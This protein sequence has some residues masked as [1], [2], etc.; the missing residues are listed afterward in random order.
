MSGLYVA[1]SQPQL[2][3][4]AIWLNLIAYSF[5]LCVSYAFRMYVGEGGACPHN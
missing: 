2:H 5:V 1:L 4:R 3:F